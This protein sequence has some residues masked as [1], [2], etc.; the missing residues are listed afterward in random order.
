MPIS[1]DYQTKNVMYRWEK[2]P[3]TKM[4]EILIYTPENTIIAR[5]AYNDFASEYDEPEQAW[6][7]AA[8]DIC[9]AMSQLDERK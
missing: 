1:A 7:Q 6:E 3:F 4:G 9:T 8:Q 5:L 2:N